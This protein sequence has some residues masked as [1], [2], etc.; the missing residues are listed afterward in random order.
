MLRLAPSLT[1]KFSGQFPFSEAGRYAKKTLS[2][3]CVDANALFN[4]DDDEE[5]TKSS[6]FGCKQP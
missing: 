4:D 5:V 6:K 2:E 1:G 3:A